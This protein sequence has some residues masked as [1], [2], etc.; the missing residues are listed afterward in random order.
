MVAT[1]VDITIYIADVVS[2]TKFAATAVSLKGVGTNDTKAL[3]EAVKLLNANKPEIQAFVEEGKNK[4]IEFFNS[5]CDFLIKEAQAL[6]SQNKF[7]EAI[8]KLLQI[9]DVSKDC[10]NTAMEVIAPIYKKK[11]ERDCQVYLLE[12][13]GAWAATQDSTGA[14]KA[15]SALA[16]LDPQASCYNE[17]KDFLSTID[18][19]ME[20]KYKREWDF[21]MKVWQDGVDIEKQRIE[22]YRQVGVAFGSNYQ[23]NIYGG[24]DWLFR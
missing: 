2:Q 16:K 1:N 22:A 18:K 15:T 24:L 13:K 21:Q 8:Y 19:A 11:I 23:G 9:P 5:K 14:R 6:E 12:A 7:E 10:Y 17:A 20:A 3:T 4:I